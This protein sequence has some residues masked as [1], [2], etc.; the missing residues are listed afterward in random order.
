MPFCRALVSA[1][2]RD[3]RAAIT[4]DN[5]P[6]W[7]DEGLMAFWEEWPAR[8]PVRPGG[9]GDDPP[10]AD[11]ACMSRKRLVDRAFDRF[12]V[13]HKEDYAPAAEEHYRGRTKRFRG[14][15]PWQIARL[16]AWTDFSGLK[17]E[18]TLSYLAHTATA[19]RIPVELMAPCDEPAKIET[20]K[21]PPEGIAGVRGGGAQSLEQVGIPGEGMPF[22]WPRDDPPDDE[23]MRAG[24]DGRRKHGAEARARVRRPETRFEIGKSARD[25]FTTPM[26]HSCSC[27]RTGGPNGVAP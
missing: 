8:T 27:S 10:V 6:G 3:E 18:Q 5:T 23:R 14:K 16:L 24:R 26:H 13:H 7:L 21:N 25:S 19:D 12:L 4:H 11:T 17:Q 2:T 1:C 15:A 22:D 9:G 20:P